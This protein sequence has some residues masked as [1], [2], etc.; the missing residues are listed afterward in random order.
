MPELTEWVLVELREQLTRLL[1]AL[2][3]PCEELPIPTST[4]PVVDAVTSMQI[5]D[6]LGVIRTAADYWPTE[7]K[8]GLVGLHVASR[9]RVTMEAYCGHAGCTAANLQHARM[10]R[11]VG[12]GGPRMSDAEI[13][14]EA[15]RAFETLLD[16]MWAWCD[17]R[18]RR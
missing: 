6:V 10:T 1:S 7:W 15:R 18:A 2:A 11:L 3:E 14:V 13:L 12:I 8:P 4:P 5:A 16:D 9:Y 17:E